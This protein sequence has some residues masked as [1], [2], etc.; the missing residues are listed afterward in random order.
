MIFFTVSFSR[1]A[2]S[3]FLT[4]NSTFYE[5][6]LLSPAVIK[7]T[8]I[9][10]CGTSFRK[11]SSEGGASSSTVSVAIGASATFRHDTTERTKANN[12]QCITLPALQKTFVDFFFEF[13][14][15]FC[16]ETWRGNSGEFF[17]V[18]VSSKMKH[19]NSSK[20]RGKFGAKFGTKIRKIRGTFI[21][22]LCDLTI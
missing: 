17:L 6:A 9:S 15:A 14:W 8:L 12:P 22:Q 19:E 4:N 10:T 5:T 2:P 21:L 7:C 11:V 18:S 1:F 3:R 16:I 20:N 13:A